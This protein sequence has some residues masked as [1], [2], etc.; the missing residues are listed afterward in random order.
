M[1]FPQ[2]TKPELIE[3]P[4]TNYNFRLLQKSWLPS[5][6]PLSPA[7]PSRASLAHKSVT[8]ARL[9]LRLAH[10]G[11]VALPAQTSRARQGRP[12]A[13]SALTPARTRSASPATLSRTVLVPMARL[14]VLP[15]SLRSAAIATRRV[16]SRATARYLPSARANQ[17]ALPHRSVTTAGS[18]RSS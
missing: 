6:S 13:R 12:S 17:S 8:P 10:P 15:S 18:L 2:Q 5:P 16:T 4:T 11:V 7:E 3:Q 9:E 1:V 14:S